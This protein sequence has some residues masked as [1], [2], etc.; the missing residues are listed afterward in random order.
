[1]ITATPEQSTLL[2]VGLT[3]EQS[4]KIKLGINRY[5]VTDWSTIR[6]N[7][8]KRILPITGDFGKLTPVVLYGLSTNEEDIP[9]FKHPF[10][11]IANGWIA[12]DAR[13]LVTPNKFDL[14]IDIRNPSELD[15]L[16]QRMIFTGLWAMKRTDELYSFKLAHRVFAN[17]IT[18]TLTRKLHLDL[19]DQ[20]TIR[21]CAYIYYANLFTDNFGIDDIEKLHVRVKDDF[22]VPAMLE[23][24]YRETEGGY[25]SLA[26][27]GE[28]IYTA[29]NNVK[30]K[31][32]SP[33]VFIQMVDNN[34]IGVNGRELVLL[35]LEHPPTW[36]SLVYASLTL[37]NFSRNYIA[38]IVDKFD[39]R[40]A[41]EEFLKSFMMLTR[42]YLEE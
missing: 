28:S 40:G 15:L 4:A 5:Q 3:H 23:K 33:A 32:L 6:R 27:F 8:E 25:T 42:Q 11:D 29:T 34:W 19:Q 21:C 22:V 41:G 2:R 20:L 31:G 9:G 1:M 17:W 38:T 18:D 26:S 14:K 7:Q 30:L 10:V 13:S 37:K 39:K 35:S 36:L 24:V 16:L 12:V